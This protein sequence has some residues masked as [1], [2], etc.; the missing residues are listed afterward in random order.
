MLIDP[1]FRWK[2]KEVRSYVAKPLLIKVVDNGNITY[3]SPSIEDI[4]KYCAHQIDTLWEEVLRFEY[5]H[6]YYV[7]LSEKMWQTKQ[8][9]LMNRQRF[10]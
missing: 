1:Q 9:L 6:K 7:D 5:P 4:R 3:S 8:N 10:D 2:K